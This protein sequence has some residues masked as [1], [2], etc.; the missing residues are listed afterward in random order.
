MS[1]SPDQPR[2]ITRNKLSCVVNRL[3]GKIV[4]LAGYKKWVN[5]RHCPDHGLVELDKKK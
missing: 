3:T 5:E 4:E 1:G 2:P